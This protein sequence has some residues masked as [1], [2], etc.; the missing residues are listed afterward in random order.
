MANTKP[1]RGITPR[2]WSQNQT[3]HELCAK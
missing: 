3:L 1:H 2:T